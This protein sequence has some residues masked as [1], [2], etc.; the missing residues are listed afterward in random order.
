MSTVLFCV[1]LILVVLVLYNTTRPLEIE[2]FNKNILPNEV[3][4]MTSRKIRI[5]NYST[6]VRKLT[7]NNDKT[8]ILVHNTPFTAQVWYPLYIYTQRLLSD[9]KKIPTIISYDLMGHGT[10]WVPVDPK[11]NDAD[12]QNVAWSL[13]TFAEQLY[14]IYKNYS[15]AEKVT[16]VGYGSGGSIA[17]AFAL[18]Y[19][20]YIQSLYVLSTTIGPTV[21]A[22]FDEMEYLVNWINSNSKDVT[23]LTM[24]KQFI[25]YNLCLW[26][27]NNNVLYCPLAENR[28]DLKNSFDTVEYLIGDKL[29]REASCQTYLQIDKML[30]VS[31][32]RDAWGAAN[33]SFSVTLLIG[34]RDHYTNVNTMKQDVK[35]VSQASPSVKMYIVNGKHGFPLTHPEYIYQ[36][37]NGDDMKSNPL[38]LE[39]LN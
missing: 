1:I 17:Q 19:P 33:V 21:T 26:F 32:L 30:G 28:N 22:I 23:Y 2:A 24:D 5:G 18:R 13:D 7:G 8:I 36:M 20:Q 38:T 9:G 35:I 6:V 27:E 4:G 29:Y 12:M 34:N 37:I 11:Y 25:N 14:Q 39:V 3:G 15:D 31:D 10:G 16:L